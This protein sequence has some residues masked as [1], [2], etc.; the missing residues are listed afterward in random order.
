[1][2]STSWASLAATRG[3][4]SGSSVSC[5]TEQC[6]YLGRLVADQ[7]RSYQAAHRAGDA[8]GRALAVEA[9]NNWA[10]I[11]TSRPGNCELP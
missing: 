10:E 7:L 3:P 9:L 4:P 8:L 2:S 11:C 1:M 6:R 5:S